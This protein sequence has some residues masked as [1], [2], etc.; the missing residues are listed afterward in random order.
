MGGPGEQPD[1]AP[2]EKKTLIGGKH[3][4][5]EKG[6]SGGELHKRNANRLGER[7]ENSGGG[8]GPKK[9]KTQ[10]GEGGLSK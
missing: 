6:N 2:W 4:V 1:P 3:H 7:G 8:R 10:E 5:G 9:K